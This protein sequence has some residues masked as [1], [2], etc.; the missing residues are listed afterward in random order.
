[1]SIV[2]WLKYMQS[3]QHK[4]DK[5][6]VSS[7]AYFQSLTMFL[8]VASENNFNSSASWKLRMMVDHIYN[9]V[10]IIIR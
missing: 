10:S 1:M 8:Q 5:Q 4:H 2:L 9:I 6:Q 7:Q 3:N